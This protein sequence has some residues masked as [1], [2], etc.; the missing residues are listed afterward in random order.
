MQCGLHVFYFAA[1]VI[2]SI[3]ILPMA[4][5]TTVQVRAIIKVQRN[6]QTL[7]SIGGAQGEKC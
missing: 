3:G 4:S 2:I 7:E 6:L 1:I 5:Y